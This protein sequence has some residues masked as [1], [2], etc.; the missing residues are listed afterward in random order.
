MLYTQVFPPQIYGAW[1]N[2]N[3]TKV[4]LG[5]PVSFLGV[6]YRHMSE[7]L[8]PVAEVTQSR[9][10]TKAHPCL[11]DHSQK[12]LHSLKAAQQVGEHPFK[13]PQLF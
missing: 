1:D 8:L 2:T 9:Y 5:K 4:Q 7:E 6:G 11:C 3:T 12:R 10:V 13:V